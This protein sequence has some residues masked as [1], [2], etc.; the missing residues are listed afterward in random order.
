[1]F[2]GFGGCDIGAVQAGLD[3]IWGLE[4]DPDL[5]SVFAN[6]FPKSKLF[7]NDAVLFDFESTT[8]Y[9]I[10]DWL[11]ASPPCTT[12]TVVNSKKESNEDV[13]IA[14]SICRAI[15]TLRPQYFSLENVRGYQ[16]YLSFNLI[17]TRLKEEGYNL[18]HFVLDCSDYGVPQVRVRLFLIASLGDLNTELPPFTPYVG[19]FKAVEDLIPTLKEIKLTGWQLDRLKSFN[20]DDMNKRDFT[21]AIQRSGARKR[22]D[23]HGKMDIPNNNIR[24]SLQPM[25]T[26]RAMSGK[27]RVNPHQV[28]IVHN[29]KV[30]ESSINCYAR[31]QSFPDSYQFSNDF[32]LNV[33]G[34]G[35][36]VPP[37]MFEKLIRSSLS[38]LDISDR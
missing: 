33:K 16:S 20:I 23:V 37:L 7:V 31:W 29:N 22:K 26:L 5:A 14:A 38:I 27:V 8:K 28:T 21:F 19:W 9:G 35:N 17:V 4:K 18:H 12:A 25:W 24:F 11:H 2:T 36:S 32:K 10:P 6:N 34:I 3:T 1:M 30:L 13:A 15:R